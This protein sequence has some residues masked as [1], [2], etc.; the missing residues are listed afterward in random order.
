MMTK[1]SFYRRCELQDI[2]GNACLLRVVAFTEPRTVFSSLASYMQALY[3]AQYALALDNLDGHGED[4][5]SWDPYLHRVM[6]THG[7]ACVHQ[8]FEA[9]E[10]AI[11]LVQVHLGATEA[12]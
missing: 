12:I 4:S 11:V 10:R 6:L 3:P 8:C 1:A 2:G 7:I 9:L 5:P